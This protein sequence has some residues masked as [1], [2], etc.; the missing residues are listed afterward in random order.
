M[1]VAPEQGIRAITALTNEAG[2]PPRSP[3]LGAAVAYLLDA[4]LPGLP[5]GVQRALRSRGLAQ[6]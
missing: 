4:N 5:I 1:T 2:R 6:L 3:T